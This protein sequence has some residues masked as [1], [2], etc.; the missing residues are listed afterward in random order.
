VTAD[1]DTAASGGREEPAASPGRARLHRVIFEADTPAGR[2]FDLTLI[3]LVLV[4]VVVVSI[5]TV[6]GLS[7]TAYRWLRVLEWTLTGLFTVEYVLRLVAVRRPLRYVTSFFG[8]VDLFAIVPTYVSLVVPGAQALLVVRVL[9]LLR[10]F[11]VLKLTRYLTEAATLGRALRAS[12]RKITVFLLAMSTIVIVVGTMMY[13]VEGPT[14]GF[15]S[16]PTSVY[17]AVVTLTTVGY[18]DISPR[19]PLGQALASVVMILGYGIIAVPT[20]IVTAELTAGGLTSSDRPPPAS[21][22]CPVCDAHEHA[23]DAR[24]CRRCGAR[25]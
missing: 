8:A 2:A 17:W 7:A 5:E 13:V 12:V 1:P 20:G 16:I 15:T 19:T 18:G 24:Y 14:H 11:R 22:A 4:S 3:A 9:R 6:R 23:A 25:L 21:G 10:V